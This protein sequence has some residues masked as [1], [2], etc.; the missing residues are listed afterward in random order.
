MSTTNIGINQLPVTNEIV[1]GDYLIIDNGTETRRLDFK[2]FIVGADNIVGVDNIIP[3]T[4]AGTGAVTTTTQNKLRESVSA[5][6]FGAVGD[7]VTNDTSAVQTAMAASS[8]IG[9]YVG[10]YNIATTPTYSGPHILEVGNGGSVTG[11]GAGVLGFSNNGLQGRQLVQR[12]T[13]GADIATQNIR[14]I[15]N[16]TGGTPGFVSSALSVRTDVTNPSATNFEWAIIGQI[17]NSATAGENV[18]IYG[19][20]NKKSTGPT[21]G[22]VAEARDLTNLD[23][24]TTGL[25]GIEVDV[26][27]NGTDSNENRVGVDV[28]TGKGVSDGTNCSAG[29]AFRAGAYAGS[30][31]VNGLRIDSSTY[32]GVALGNSGTYGVKVLAS[33]VLAVGID[34]S[35]GTYSASALR[36]GLKTSKIDLE[37]TATLQIDVSSGSN[38]VRLLSGGVE[39]CGLDL[40]TPSLR[41][42]GTKVVGVRENG[43]TAFT[44]TVD[45]TTTYNTGTVTLVQLAQRV[46]A[47]QAALT[48]HGLISI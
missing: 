33:A 7:G 48:T 13:T 38:I 6:D 21:W 47:L 11:A 32:A 15:A 27:A 4:P 35:Q 37:P 19:Q 9:F 14:R 25:I 45:K 22:M 28:V 24:P 39:K 16:H 17:H 46:A 41:I 42:A 18:G 1:N 2:D 36:L 40:D 23:N 8:D 3:Y 12:N 26:F 20:G 29:Y 43:F 34:L 10:N 44:G 31:F 30:S 5:K